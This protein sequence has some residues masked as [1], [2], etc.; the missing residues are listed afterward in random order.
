[1]MGI[2]LPTR[3]RYESLVRCLNSIK[4]CDMSSE[5]ELIIISDNDIESLNIV[6][7]FFQE[8]NPFH[9]L[10]IYDS[11]IRLLSVSAFLE[12]FKYCNS[13]IFCWINDECYFEKSYFSN[14]YIEFIKQ[15]PDLIGVI[16]SGGKKNKANFGITSKSFV[17][18]NEGEWFHP[19]YKI[20]FCDDELACRAILLGRYYFLRNSGIYNDIEVTNSIPLLDPSMK[21][22][23]KRKDR[24]LF[25]ERSETN[26]G[27]SENRIYSW[28]GFRDIN[29]PLKAKREE[30]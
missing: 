13:E 21:L 5:F 17:K 27:L 16:S 29:L 12:A 26:F 6:M 28:N 30:K 22:F 7:N 1:M 25:Y 3:G 11:K 15:F 23:L 2:L 19:G 20:N 9:K 18:Y 10:I 24:G 8:E 4:E 14:L